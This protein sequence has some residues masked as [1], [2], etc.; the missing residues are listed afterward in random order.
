MFSQL[1]SPFS[2]ITDLAGSIV[3]GTGFADAVTGA[4]DSAVS[5]AISDATGSVTSQLP[6]G[7]GSIADD[8]I[9]DIIP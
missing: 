3:G 7:L 6:G 8:A 4:V 9:G 5:G 2:G 1:L